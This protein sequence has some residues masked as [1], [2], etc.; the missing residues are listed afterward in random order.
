MTDDLFDP[1]LTEHRNPRTAAI[2]RATPLEI[3]D[4]IAVEDGTVPAAVHAERENIARAMEL[5]V[6]SFRRGGR[7]IYVGAGTS[8]RLG[9]LDAT[10]CPPTF[11]VDPE[12]VQGVI[13]GGYAALVRSQEGAEDRPEDGAADIDDREVGSKDFVFGI[14]TSSTTPYVRGA[15]ARASERGA[16]T[17][18]LCCTEPGDEMRRWV[19]VCIVPLVG[20]E[21]IAGSTRMKAGTATKLVLNTITTGAMIRLGKVYGN[22]MVDLQAMSEKLIDRSRRIVMAATGC[23]ADEAAGLVEEAGGSVKT[24]IVMGLAGIGRELAELGLSEA[25][26]FVSV[27]LDTAEAERSGDSPYAPYPAAPPDPEA[28]EHLQALLRQLPGRLAGLVADAEDAKLRRRPRDGAW[29]VKEHIEHLIDCDRL[30]ALRLKAMVERDDPVIADRDDE[31]ENR[32]VADT[33][34]RETPVS[35]L[36]R[37]LDDGRGSLA[38]RLETAPLETFARVGRHEAHGSI[39]VYQLLRHVVRHDDHHLQAIRRLLA[40]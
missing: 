29:C 16:H 23:G 35:E 6:E 24:A 17:G 21:V 28:L 22:L 12:L 38:R 11:G 10:E 7:L 19:D 1:R 18:F 32:K 5:A 33:A 37:R 3:V 26:G 20:P 40:D 2:D 30:V 34:A 15:L 9:V 13:A 31:R 14:A 4:L 8:G 36:L 27:A 25:A 39:T